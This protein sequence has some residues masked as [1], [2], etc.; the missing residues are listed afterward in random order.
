MLSFDLA[1]VFRFVHLIVAP[2][3]SKSPVSPHDMEQIA[4]Y[5]IHFGFLF[6]HAFFSL[7]I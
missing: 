2:Q 4:K 7:L 3:F 6:R 5:S 1:F